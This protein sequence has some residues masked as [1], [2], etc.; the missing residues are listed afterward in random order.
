MAQDLEDA[1]H[2][3]IGPALNLAEARSFAADR[4]PDLALLDINL[5]GRG[6]GIVLARELASAQGVP[7]LFVSGQVGEARANADAALGILH[8]PYD[9]HALAASVRVAFELIC[10][11]TP[12]C[13]PG[14]LELFVH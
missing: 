14:D 7:C 9:A 10:G 6:E 3:V 4:R 2:E 12:R 8:K 1:G 5:P 13:A 11:R